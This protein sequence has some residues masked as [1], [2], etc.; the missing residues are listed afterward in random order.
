MK[1][2]IISD[3]HTEFKA[4][5]PGS[6]DFLKS[7][8]DV[9]VVAG[10]LTTWRHLEENIIYLCDMFPEVV[11][12]AGNH[13]YY[14]ASFQYVEMILR[15]LQA[16][17]DN[18]NWLHNS[19]VKIGGH[20]FIG[21]TLWFERNYQSEDKTNQLYLNDFRMVKDCD[22]IAFNRYDESYLYL[23]SGIDKGDIVVTHHLPSERSVPHRFKF[24]TLNCYF[25][26]P[27]DDLIRQ[28]RPAIWIHGHTHDPC[29]YDIGDTRILCNPLGYPHENNKNFKRQLFIE[30]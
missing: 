3:T 20:R 16:K 6:L 28:T 15:D 23:K 7:D 27:L 10:D 2:Q 12:V 19:H 22:P 4:G 17:L 26:N 29:D 5:V 30:L 1:V 21:C 9:L 13:E 14:N 18:F 25:A 11:Y 8:A 24:S